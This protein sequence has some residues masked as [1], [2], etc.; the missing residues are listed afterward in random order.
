MKNVKFISLLLLLGWISA[1]ILTYRGQAPELA[2][3][4]D[5]LTIQK[6]GP[7]IQAAFKEACYDCHSYQTRY[8]WYAYIPPFSNWIDG[9]VNQGRADLNFSEWGAIGK[10]LRDDIARET[11]EAI[12]EEAM[13]LSSYRW[14]HAGARW[15]K[16]T[17]DAV[18]HFLSGV[19]DTCSQQAGRLI[20][21]CEGCEAVFE[22]GD[23]PLSPVDTLPDFNDP[24]K[25][26]K[27]TGTIYEKGGKTPA[28]GVILYVYHTNQEGIYP[29]RGDE[30]GWGR[31]HGYI[32]GWIKT[33]SDGRYAFYTL[34]PGVYPS[35]SAPAHIHPIILEP[36]G[37]YYW[38]GSYHFE[39][40]P[41]LSER[42]AHPVNPRGGSSGLLELRK[43]G[44]LWI[45]KRDIILGKN[46]PGYFD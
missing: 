44:D 8:P 38:L 34:Q 29:T 26:I 36:N 7:E 27:V 30:K 37:K 32:R 31:R 13:P 11:A 18:L 24:G 35:R 20:G 21:S 16:E 10:E 41:L 25:K 33:G 9:H 46:I 4:D 43:E 2:P 39:D 22:Y 12:K 6:A 14:M 40:D 19:Q 3:A 45:G 17:R 42:E 23:Q 15:P 28:E 1:G 5:F